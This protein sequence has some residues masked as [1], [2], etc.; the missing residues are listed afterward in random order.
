VRKGGDQ[1]KGRGLLVGGR[2]E[3]AAMGDIVLLIGGGLALAALARRLFY[4]RLL[5]PEPARAGREGGREE[6]GKRA[7][8]RKVRGRGRKGGGKEGG[9]QERKGQPLPV[10]CEWGVWVVM[11]STDGR[12]DGRRATHF[13]EGSMGS[14]WYWS[15]DGTS[16]LSMRREL[17]RLP[18]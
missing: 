6:A 7:R 1:G 13:L 2:V 15:Q 9:K 18:W 3:V 4:P 14:S 17:V 5:L 11:Q 8:R 16:T 10:R 12:T